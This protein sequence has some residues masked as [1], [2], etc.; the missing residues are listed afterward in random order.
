MTIREKVMLRIINEFTDE[1]DW[2]EKVRTIF[3]YQL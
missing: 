2:F 3:E 1:K